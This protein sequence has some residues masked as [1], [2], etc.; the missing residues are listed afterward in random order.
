MQFLGL[1]L[2]LMYNYIFIFHGLLAI[3]TQL[4]IFREL[5]V[6]FYGNELFLGTFLSSWLF[7]VGM[8]SLLI[9]RLLLKA[10]LK[11][12]YFAY[13]FLTISIFLPF[14]FVLVRLSKNIFA[15]GQ[16]I[17]P[18]GTTLYTFIVMS[19]ICFVIGGQFSLACAIAGDKIKTGSAL[20]RVYLYETL[21]AVVGG[22]LFTYILIGKV[23]TFIIA[24]ILSFISVF[25]GWIL[26][27]L[28]KKMSTKNLLLIAVSL[29]IISV[30]FKIE[31]TV[32]RLQWRKYTF[33]QQKENRNTTLSLVKLGSIK[34]IFVD[35][36]LAA[37][38]PNPEN[39]EPVA[40]WPLL[41]IDTPYR[42]LVVGDMSLGILKEV[43]K[44]NPQSVDYVV[45]DNS[46][47]DVVTDYLDPEDRAALRDSRL[48][49]HYQDSR[50]FV[51][52]NKNQYDA[53]IMN[54]QEVPN[55]KL[56]RFFTQE[57]YAQLKFILRPKGI[58]ALSIVSSE[59]YFSRQ[60]QMF[61][62]SVYQTIKS[63]FETIEIIP[64]ESMM[65]LCSSSA[66][67][68]QLETILTR[69]N[70]REIASRYVIPAYIEYKLDV[71]R[72]A[73]IETLLA[74]TPGVEI[75]RDFEPTTYH[76]FA[77][78]W[79]NKFVSPL[80]Y[81]MGIIFLGMLIF[82][83]FSGKSSLRYLAQ[84]KECILLFKFGFISILLEL[85]LLFSFQII[86]GYVYWQMGILF[87]AFM[88][89]LFLGSA[90]GGL[91]KYKNRQMHFLFLIVLSVTIVILTIYLR[92]LLP[93]LVDLSPNQNI[94]IFL[95][96]LILIGCLSG[97]AFVIAGF[98]I[99]EQE[100]LVKAGSLYSADLWGAASGAILS[101]NFIIPK[102]GLLGAFTFAAIMGVVSLAIFLVLSF[103]RGL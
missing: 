52:N 79:Q 63:V 51:K 62:A 27:R 21:G 43:L 55:L 14:V 49:I 87:A 47:I 24:V 95:M 48:N 37:S 9:R 85:L 30:N 90:L 72:R 36:L 64:G 18:I 10:Q 2:L 39:Y 88:L 35:G 69:F 8:G 97:A 5:S 16:L 4:V 38:F 15:F 23:P 102:F 28:E 34:S 6:L 58:L 98:F 1:I 57:F 20:G 54:I 96:C 56:N 91:S 7:W 53:V 44:H 77:N 29:A 33:I 26:L 99:K 25:V 75:N 84:R 3:L 13:G 68:I 86:S 11:V 74:E 66:I 17:G 12:D 42:I 103:N 46:F 89:G 83:F 60:T 81:L 32:N 70:N 76:Y 31:P 59:N 94:L 93:Q 22:V 50:L 92:F 41:A 19:C 67:D 73:D 71:N 61:N 100:M 65:F 40:H 82:V 101:A 45:L 78:L 80:G